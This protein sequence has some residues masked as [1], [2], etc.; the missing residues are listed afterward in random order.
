VLIAREEGGAVDLVYGWGLTPIDREAVLHAVVSGGGAM[1]LAYAGFVRATDRAS[2][3]QVRG[4][5]AAG[6]GFLMSASASIYLRDRAI[7]GPAVSFAGCLIVVAGMRMLL[8]DRLERQDAARR[9]AARRAGR[10]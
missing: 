10:E 1:L 8:R 6:I 3:L 9:D 2:A 5:V 7:V 4:L